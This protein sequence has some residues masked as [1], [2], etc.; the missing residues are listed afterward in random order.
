[1]ELIWK[2]I[3]KLFQWDTLFCNKVI[4]PCLINSVT[5]C[6]YFIAKFWLFLTYCWYFR[7]F[8]YF[9][10]ISD[11]FWLFLKNPIWSLCLRSKLP[12]FL[13]E[14]KTRIL[15][16]SSRWPGVVSR[17]HKFLWDECHDHRG[18]KLHLKTSFIKQVCI[19]GM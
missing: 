18:R 19:L 9:L 5:R 16:W 4:V 8:F 10:A 1:M 17:Q 3:Y 2:L 15:L 14:A 13:L 6:G 12:V 11:I 7:T